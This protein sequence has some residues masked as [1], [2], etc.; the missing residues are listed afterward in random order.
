MAR[1]RGKD[2]APELAV[3]RILRRMGVRFRLHRKGLPGTPD[4][5]L[6]RRKMIIF[7]H[8]C[9]WHGHGCSAGRLPKSRIEF[10]SAKIAGN[11]IRDAKNLRVLRHSGWSVLVLWEC[12][13]RKI[14]KLEARLKLFLAGGVR[15]ARPSSRS[16]LCRSRA[17][18]RRRSDAQ[19]RVAVQPIPE[20]RD[21]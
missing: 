19:E 13:T 10:W 11:R 16:A 20:R 18:H 9:Y 5:V 4:V 1:I 17:R 2:T 12:Q 14:S 15:K 6:P 21:F 8:G 3:R 7:I